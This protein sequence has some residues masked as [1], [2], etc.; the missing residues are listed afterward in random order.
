MVGSVDLEKVVVNNERSK[1]KGIGMQ[2]F[3]HIRYRRLYYLVWGR[4]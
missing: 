4:I 3:E 2:I 1:I